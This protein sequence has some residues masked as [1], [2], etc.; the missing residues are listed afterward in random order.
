MGDDAQPI[1]SSLTPYLN[2]AHHDDPTMAFIDVESLSN[3]SLVGFVLNTEERAVIS[4]SLRLKA[5]AEQLAGGIY[6][7]GKIIGVN[8]DY[9]IAQ[10]PQESLFNRKFYYSLDLTSWLQLPEVSS[11]DMVKIEKLTGRFTGDPAFEYSNGSED[12]QEERKEGEPEKPKV[13]E[14]KRLAGIVAL[15]NYEVEVVPRGAFYRDAMHKLDYNPMF[16]GLPAVDLGQLTSYFH[17][18]EGFNINLRT[19]AERSAGFEESID[20][21]Q[22]IAKDEPN[23]V[24][25]IQVERGGSVA[26]LRSLQ[27]PGY[28]SF[29]SPSP[30]KWGGFYYGTGIKNWNIGK[31]KLEVVVEPVLVVEPSR[32]PTPQPNGKRRFSLSPDK[33]PATPP[34]P[35]VAFKVIPS[36]DDELI[37]ACGD[38]VTGTDVIDAAELVAVDAAGDLYAPPGDGNGEPFMAE[39]ND[40]FSKILS[41][42]GRRRKYAV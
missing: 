27:W 9:L 23:G 10:A 30:A 13:N 18:R 28:S 4:T 22:T 35:D 32:P 16:K 3:F 39:D 11:D 34:V 6:L 37:R 8:K 36:A 21:F 5:Q 1:S 2:S 29:H 42:L 19:L 17:F 40:Q 7:W 15:I 14:E 20:I 26:I 41:I 33:A 24:W 31:K 38:N 12:E 25:T